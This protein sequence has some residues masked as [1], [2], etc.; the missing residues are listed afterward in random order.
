MAWVTVILETELML[1]YSSCADV[2]T[3]AA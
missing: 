2:R 3:S 1:E